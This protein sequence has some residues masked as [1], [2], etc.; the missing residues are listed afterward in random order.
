MPYC[1]CY[2]VLSASAD[3]T[4]PVGFGGSAVCMPT[5][6]RQRSSDPAAVPKTSSAGGEAA[7][8]EH[9][10]AL[11]C[12]VRSFPSADPRSLLKMPS[13]TDRSGPCYRHASPRLVHAV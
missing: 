8:H 2:G 9:Q 3:A 4:V 1:A 5:A 12:E 10:N 11:T 13:T 6:L 7:S